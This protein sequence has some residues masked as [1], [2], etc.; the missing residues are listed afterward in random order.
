MTFYV[1]LFVAAKAETKFKD[2]MLQ[3]QASAQKHL[4]DYLDAE[5]VSS[6]EEDIND[7][8][9]IESIYKSFKQTSGRQYF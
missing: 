3:H 5:Y 1:I 8:D 6:E 7:S 2:A 9:I 4:D